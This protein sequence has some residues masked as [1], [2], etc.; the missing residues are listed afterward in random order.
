MKT[1]ISV[2]DVSKLYRMGAGPYRTLRESLTEPA[3][4]SW[5]RV[6][7]MMKKEATGLRRRSG[8]AASVNGCHKTQRSEIWALKDVSCEI[9]HGEVLGLIGRNG[10][11]K[12]T[13]LKILS[14]ITS[15]TAGQ[16][17]LHGRVGSL[18]EV[19]TGFH[20]ELTGREN[21]Y[22]NGAI[23][24]MS[25][26][27]VRARFDEIIAF[28]ELEEFLD[29][30]VKH[31]SSG[32]YMRLAFAVASHLESEIL[33]VDEVLA[34]GDAAFQKKCLGKMG[35]VS[36]QGRT[37]I[38]V[39]HNLAAVKSLCSRAL[40]IEGGTVAMDG[41]VNDVVNRYLTAGTDMSQTGIIPETAPRHQD[42][43]G[44][45]LFRSVRL[46]DLEGNETAQLF[47]GQPFK[48][49]FTCDVQKDIPDGLFEISISTPDGTQV[50][51]S[52]TM[53]AGQG[54][55]RLSR[56]RHEVSAVFDVVLLP[57][58]YTI[59]V[60]VHHH[61]GTTA[62]MVQ[63]TLDFSVLRISEDRHVH[64][65]WPRTRGFVQTPAVWEQVVV[66]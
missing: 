66:N 37:V 41:D 52:T 32:M 6:R 45:A 51:S 28:A 48:V 12:S 10:A 42:V 36:R 49:S 50:T 18:L 26:T 25:Q 2:K 39:S 9:G 62:D 33:L 30:P 3:A 15:P 14:R 38:L 19:G 53:D 24:G 16:I 43:R 11:G 46:T 59:D 22:L 55:R 31:Y 64:Y 17:I 56:G 60:G 27:E 54:T 13:L 29:M 4:A 47:F 61:N 1:A 7:N 57:R 20:P 58:E 21:I 23:L 63:R 65:P 35:Q 5:R 44:E 8:L 34:V 40:L